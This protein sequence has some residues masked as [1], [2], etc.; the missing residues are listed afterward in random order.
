MT[1]IPD[2]S[3]RDESPQANRAGRERAS[4]AERTDSQ[5]QGRLPVDAPIIRRHPGGWS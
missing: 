5:R 1:S 3:P 2:Q 4:Q